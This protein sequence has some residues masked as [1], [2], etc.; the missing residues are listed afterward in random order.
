M[1]I[2]NKTVYVTDETLKYLSDYPEAPY[3]YTGITSFLNKCKYGENVN[4]V[5]VTWEENRSA[6]VTEKQVD[7]IVS[8]WS[9]SR[10][11][12]LIDFLKQE[13]FKDAK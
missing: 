11:T 10:Q 9:H 3:H 8:K 12:V 2:K 4:K 13:I 5:T 6:T 7:E 1:T